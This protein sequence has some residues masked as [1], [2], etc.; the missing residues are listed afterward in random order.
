VKTNATRAQLIEAL[1]E[2]ARELRCSAWIGQ[3]DDARLEFTLNHA[4]IWCQQAA[5]AFKA[6]DLLGTPYE[7][8]T[9]ACALRPWTGVA[10]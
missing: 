5:V 1:E 8:F 4:P 3:G 7:A 2:A 9:S 6:M 10:P